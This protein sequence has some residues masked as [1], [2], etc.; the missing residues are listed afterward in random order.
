MKVCCQVFCIAN[1]L[2]DEP[3]FPVELPASASSVV[4][5]SKVSCLVDSVVEDCNFVEELAVEDT[6]A[7]ED[8][9]VVGCIVVLG[10]IASVVESCKTAYKESL[11]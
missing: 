6:A 7:V 5:T 8:C 4:V 2:R 11:I 9:V 3:C 10:V 1:N